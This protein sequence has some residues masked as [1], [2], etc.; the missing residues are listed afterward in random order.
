MLKPVVYKF[1]ESD[2]VFDN[3]FKDIKLLKNEDL[4]LWVVKKEF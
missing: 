3:K 4:P 2:N 1:L